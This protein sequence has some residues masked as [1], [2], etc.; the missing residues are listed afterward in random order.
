MDIYNKALSKSDNRI[1]YVESKIENF[2]SR[3]DNVE[4]GIRNA[5]KGLGF[6]LNE[7]S[8]IKL[9]L[10]YDSSF[11]NLVDKRM[12]ELN[13]DSKKKRQIITIIMTKIKFSFYFVF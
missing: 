12:E 8:K 9:K 5:K 10:E 7:L 1:E 13:N 3:L 6:A 11:M 4:Y 2:K